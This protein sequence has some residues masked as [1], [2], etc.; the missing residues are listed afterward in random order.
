MPIAVPVIAIGI[1]A[2][3]IGVYI[4]LRDMLSTA[5]NARQMIIAIIIELLLCSMLLIGSRMTAP[6]IEQMMRNLGVLSLSRSSPPTPQTRILMM[7]LLMIANEVANPTL[8]PNTPLRYGLRYVQAETH[9][10]MPITMNPLIH[11]TG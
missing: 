8:V 4:P 11:V 7:L 9:V 6:T 10:K 1:L 5:M 2:S 3:G